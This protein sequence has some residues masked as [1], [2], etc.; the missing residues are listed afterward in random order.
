M[1]V[2]SYL[3][4]FALI[5][6]FM[7]QEDAEV[8]WHCRNGLVLAAASFLFNLVLGFILSFIPCLGCLF[9][10]VIVIPIVIFFIYCIVK[11]LDGHRVVVPYLSDLTE[12]F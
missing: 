2:L 5:P 3:G 6:Y 8:K 10:F 7:E 4:P 11:A 9:Q 1:L 12:Q